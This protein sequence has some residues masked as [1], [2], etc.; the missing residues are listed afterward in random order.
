M[1]RITWCPLSL[2]TDICVPIDIDFDLPF[3]Q[4]LEEG[5]EEGLEL[6]PVDGLIA[7]HVQQVEDVL[8][9]VLGGRLPADQIDDRLH[10]PREFG[11][12]E[13][14]VL[15]DVEGVEDFVEQHRD[16]LFGEVSL[17]GHG[18]NYRIN[19][20]TRQ[21][22]PQIWTQRDGNRQYFGGD[23]EGK[24]LYLSK[25]GNLVCFWAVFEFQNLCIL[26]LIN[27]HQIYIHTTHT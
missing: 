16:V 23:F 8:D 26:S 17:R 20:D 13:A 14:V 22:Y 21:H 2:F 11:L 25:C 9:V 1:G 3:L 10:Y 6:L 4:D 5:G 24:G 12:G 15:V 7:V 18:F 19:N 27:Y